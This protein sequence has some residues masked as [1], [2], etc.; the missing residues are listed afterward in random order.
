M[1]KGKRE[2]GIEP[3]GMPTRREVLGS[4]LGLAGL[5]AAGRLPQ[6][7]HAGTHPP[8]RAKNLIYIFLSGGT[9]QIDLFDPK[10]ELARRD[11]QRAPDELYEGK[12]LAFIRSHPTILGSPYAFKQ[13]GQSGAEV[14]ELMPHLAKVVDDLTFIKSMHCDEFNHGPAQL[15][16]STGIG[17]FGR[18][19][20]GS[21]LDYAIG[22]EN[23]DLP[24]FINLLG[25][26]KIPA[27]ASSLWSA[28]M[29]PGKHQGVRFAPSHSPVFYLENP[30]GVSIGMQQE[31]VA[32]I[33]ALNEIALDRDGNP[34][35]AT[36][37]A[38][39]DLALRM[40]KA[41]PEAVDL[42]QESQATIKDYQVRLTPTSFGKQCL[43]AR[44]LVERGVRT[45]QVIDTGWD[46]HSAIF[47]FVKP[48]ARK[49]DRPIAALIRDLKQ[50]GLLDETL[51]VCISEFGR[52]PIAQAIDLTGREADPGRDHQRDAFTV[53]L[54]GA[55]VKPG[56]TYGKTHELGHQIVENPVHIHDLN[57]TI[58]HLMGLDHEQLT[59]RYEGRNHRLTDVHGHVVH[60]ILA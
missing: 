33:N 50:R 57:A 54:A 44:R 53:W 46:H 4:G 27:A 30:P 51:V 42:S 28:G 26:R 13:H 25:S 8:A 18:P 3:A 40:Q 5:L 43:L 35:T 60:D 23:N 48:S 37:M 29:L 41:L 39:Y 19:S 22:T 49:V 9:S 10:P 15:Q 38:Q 7:A 59:F 21:W 55:G 1:A 17:R 31:D 6:L 36:R 34:E 16:L 11:G 58:L 2:S 45:V 14:S 20:I 56:M 12:R 47:R 24:G 52:T 32:A